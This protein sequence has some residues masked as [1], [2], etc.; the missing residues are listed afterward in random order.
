MENKENEVVMGDPKHC[1]DPRYVPA[2]ENILKENILF[3]EGNSVLYAAT[4]VTPDGLVP[5]IP[6]DIGFYPE[7]ESITFVS[8]ATSEHGVREVV[9]ITKDGFFYNDQYIA[10]AGEAHALLLKVMRM[11]QGA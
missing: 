3:A 2:K 11:Y 9:K 1:T 4:V 6:S 7:G 5:F 8:P 10:D